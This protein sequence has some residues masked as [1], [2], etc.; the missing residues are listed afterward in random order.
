MQMSIFY[1]NSPH[2]QPFTTHHHQYPLAFAYWSLDLFKGDMNGSC[3]IQNFL[4]IFVA[5]C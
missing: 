1:V 5:K 4:H 3:A 2:P